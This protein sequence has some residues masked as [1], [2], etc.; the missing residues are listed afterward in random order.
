MACRLAL[1]WKSRLLR[2]NPMI[3][4]LFQTRLM[5]GVVGLLAMTS[6]AA[7]AADWSVSGYGSIG[8]SYENE[9]N[10]GFLRNIAQPDEYQRNGSFKPD[11]NIG[12]QFDLQLDPQW[13]VTTQWVMK[14]R[15]EQRFDDITELAFVRY[16]PDE[17]WDIRLGRLGLN[18]YIAADSRRIDYAHLWLRPPQEFYGGIF[19]DAI[20]GIDVTYRSQWDEITWSLGA[21]YGRIKQKLQN[22]AS[23]EISATQSDQTLALVFSL[24]QDRWFGRL[25][26]VHVGQLKVDLD[27]NSLLGIQVVNQLAQAGLGPISAEA[28][29]LAEQINLQ[30]ETI[31]YWQLGFGYRDEQWS[32]QSEIYTIL[33]EKAVVPEGV[34]GY[35]IAGYTLGNVT[36]YV[37]YGRFNPKNAPYQ[38]QSDWGLSPVNGTQL[39]EV[40]KWLIGGINS[41]YIDQQTFSLG[42]R[43]DVTAQI[44]LK[45]QYDY[46]QIA[47]N[48]Y[49][50][51][52]IPLDADLQGRD[53]QLFSISVN[54]VF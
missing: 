13:S 25:S 41:T 36:P 43:W 17:N 19:Y 45:A 9:E 38:A 5:S 1:W 16:T 44:A 6:G 21:Q 49:G 10:L 11:S 28:A 7:L 53:V 33:G 15:V 18:A 31:E 32:L 30:E 8:Y 40:Q 51:W 29:Q 24:E 48:G 23:S 20:D 39:A 26:Y 3:R 27:G 35:A 46:I 42:V 47:D 52:A 12:V 34:G 54:F 4:S 2:D 37:I 14:E 50:L 22:T